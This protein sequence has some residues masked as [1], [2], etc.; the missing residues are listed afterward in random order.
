MTD[1]ERLI[2]DEALGR[3][4]AALDLVRMLMQLLV[5]GN[6]M[7]APLLLNGLRAS[8]HMTEDARAN[9]DATPDVPVEHREVRAT[10]EVLRD[11]PTFRAALAAKRG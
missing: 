10:L 5:E 1:E 4:D 6:V 7:P 2:L 9:P 3:A 8:M 11:L